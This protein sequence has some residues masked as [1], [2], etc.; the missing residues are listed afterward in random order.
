[1][2]TD[3]GVLTQPSTV[4]KATLMTPDQFISTMHRQRADQM[5][6][7]LAM[8]DLANLL[9]PELKAQW[10]Q[11]LQSRI[12]TARKAAPSLPTDQR[13]GVL[14]MATALD[15]LHRSMAR[16]AEPASKIDG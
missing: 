10:M 3:N 4:T 1:M 15:Y 6:M 16:P 8:E 14:A 9:A 13:E 7:R 11:A 2:A 5:A 12:A